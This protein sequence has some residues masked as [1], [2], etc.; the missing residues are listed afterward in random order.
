MATSK[1]S[2]EEQRRKEQAEA[3]RLSLE[4][5]AKLQMEEEAR[6]KSIDED[7]ELARQLSG[8]DDRKDR[9]VEH[10]E[11]EKGEESRVVERRLKLAE[12]EQYHLLLKNITAEHAQLASM[13]PAVDSI[14]LQEDNVHLFSNAGPIRAAYN[15][16]IAL[17]AK[18]GLS[19][20]S[21]TIIPVCEAINKMMSEIQDNLEADAVKAASG[22]RAAVAIGLRADSV[23][24]GTNVAIA[25]NSIKASTTVD[26]ETGVALQ[27]LIVRTWSLVTCD[28]LVHSRSPEMVVRNLSLNHETGGGCIPGI[29][30]RL[31]VPYVYSIRILLEVM[32]QGVLPIPKGVNTA[33]L[34]PSAM[35]S[36]TPTLIM[37]RSAAASK[38]SALDESAVVD[39]TPH[40]EEAVR[41]R[42]MFIDLKIALKEFDASRR[43][44]T[45]ATHRSTLMGWSVAQIQETTRQD[46]DRVEALKERANASGITLKF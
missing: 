15:Y 21:M 8:L 28:I 33:V 44:A 37:K 23:T 3:E 29:I 13:C 18:Y 6:L 36:Y 41:I 42:G 14:G 45:L 9:A 20:A 46:T 31:M 1:E 32:S 35:V 17:D 27:E 39:K 22:G 43:E 4:F 5:I 19:R 24:I 7:A 26:S 2:M 16:A 10:K 34:S 12:E 38:I 11:E 40:V 25:I 30:V